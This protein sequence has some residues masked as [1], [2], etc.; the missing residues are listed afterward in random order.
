MG[1]GQPTANGTVVSLDYAQKGAGSDLG[2][3]YYVRS[4]DSGVTW[5]TPVKLNTDSGT[6]MQWQPSMATTQAG[7]IFA[8]WYDQREVNGGA[9]LNCTAGSARTAIGAGGGSRL[10]TARPGSPMTRSGGH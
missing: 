10:T 9:D 2:D 3:V 8:S 6:A 7:A 4:T 1:W 5:G